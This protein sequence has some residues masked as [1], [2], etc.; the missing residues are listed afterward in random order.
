MI[1]VTGWT[2]VRSFAPKAFAAQDD[3]GLP[4]QNHRV[5]RRSN[6]LSRSRLQNDRGDDAGKQ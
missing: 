3:H 4:D 5:L 6:F 2:V 1:R